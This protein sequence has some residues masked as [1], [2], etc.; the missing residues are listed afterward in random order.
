MKSL[1]LL[2]L[3]TFAKA[4]PSFEGKLSLNST[5]STTL[6]EGGIPRSCLYYLNQG[7]RQNGFY[8]LYDYNNQI[9]VAFCDLSN[10]PG[11]AWTLVMSWMTEKYRGLPNFKS[12]VF[13]EDAPINEDSPNWQIYRQTYYQMYSIRQRSTHWRATCNVQE[14]TSTIDYQDYLRGKFSDFDIMNHDSVGSCQPVE[15]VNILGKV[16]GRGTTVGLWQYYN[17]YLLHIDSSDTGCE[18]IPFAVPRVDYF[19]YYGNGMSSKFHCSQSLYSTTQWWFG[20]YLEE[21]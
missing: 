12:K 20:G 1:L 4:S 3:L 13:Y 17:S 21:H 10:E 15:Y 2:L 16:G 18:Y 9:Y 14:Y 11:S 19:G 5:N 6:K 8:Q 7:I